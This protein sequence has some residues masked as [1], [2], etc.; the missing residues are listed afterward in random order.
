MPSDFL[1]LHFFVEK[2]F[3]FHFFFSGH[4]TMER[5]PSQPKMDCFEP[6]LNPIW[7][8]FDVIRPIG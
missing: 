4:A 2:K 3:F 8:V 6:K 7:T 1:K 5:C